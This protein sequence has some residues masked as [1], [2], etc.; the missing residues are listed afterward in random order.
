MEQLIKDSIIK[1][2]VFSVYGDLGPQAL[3]VWPELTKLD[4]NNS[5]HECKIEEDIAYL[6]N[7]DATQIAIKN[8]SLLI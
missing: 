7:R 2:I 8:L 4:N 3:Y 6:T 5:N 1:A